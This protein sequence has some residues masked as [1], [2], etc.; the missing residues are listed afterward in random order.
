MTRQLHAAVPT[1]E[2]PGSRLQKA[3]HSN[4]AMSSIEFLR[5]TGRCL[6][7]EYQINYLSAGRDLLRFGSPRQVDGQPLVVASPCY[8]GRRQ[9]SKTSCSI[10]GPTSTTIA[11]IP[12]WK[13]ECPIRRSPDQSPISARFDGSPTAGPCIRPQ[14]L[15][16]SLEDSGS[17][18]HPVNL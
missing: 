8:S 17:L 1:S 16:D 13:G 14:W 4:E 18:R 2:T 15:P 10:S 5:S 9:I 6:I 7:D 11:R 12:H 3:E